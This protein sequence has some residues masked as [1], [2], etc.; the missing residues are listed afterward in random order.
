MLALKIENLGKRYLLHHHRETRIYDVL[1]NFVHRLGRRI[2]HPFAE[3][4]IPQG[5]EEFWA[6]RNL[7]LDIEQGERV[8]FVGHN[9][10]GKSTLLKLLSRITDPTEGRIGIKGRVASL[11]EVGTGFHPDLTGRENIYLN[12]AILGMRVQEIRKN[13]NDIV[14]FSGVEKFL[15]TPVKRYSSGMYVRLAFA[16]AAH[17]SSEI[18]IVDEVL[19][20]GDMEFQK[21]CMGKMDEISHKEG[22]TI[23][24]V[25][26]NMGAVLQLCNR[27]VCL[28]SGKQVFD[29]VNVVDG[30]QKYMSMSQRK[31]NDAEWHN[32]GDKYE[33]E[34]FKP[35]RFGLYNANGEVNFAS[36]S[37]E[38]ELYVE[39]EGIVK[40]PDEKL[41]VGYALHTIEGTLLY[42]T[43]HSDQVG[44]TDEIPTLDGHVCLRSRVPLEQLNLGEK[45]LDLAIRVYGGDWIA[46]PGGTKPLSV[47][48]NLEGPLNKSPYCVLRRSGPM[49]INAGWK[50]REA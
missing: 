41:C 3:R 18:L 36:V 34:Y 42:W 47:S 35:L 29:T 19:A 16:I 17:L 2:R 24:F 46:V 49:A 44:S 4:S 11:L 9:G 26:H 6:L 30:V 25:S 28:E 14:E 27:V 21:K 32:P 37:R 7:T 8:A 39:I 20:V 22:R 33:N 12:A 48:F 40:K 50:I 23:L 38:D 1:G 13:F 43:Y 31:A 15:D 5:S 10:A 45:R